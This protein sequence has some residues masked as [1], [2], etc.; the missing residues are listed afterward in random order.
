[1]TTRVF[2]YG[3][4]MRGF[5]NHRTLRGAAFVG[6]A[7]TAPRYTLVDLGA[8]PA[9]LEGGDTAVVGE[10]YDVPPAV[11][12]RVDALEGHPTFYERKRVELEGGEEVEAYVL[13]RQS[14]RAEEKIQSGDW[15][16]RRSCSS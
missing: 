8:F 7:V 2:V 14:R 10:L 11:L 12:P 15:R 4:L 13:P 16:R 5:G 9:L 1:M 6:G 3:S